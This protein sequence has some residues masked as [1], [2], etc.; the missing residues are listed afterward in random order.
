MNAKRIEETGRHHRA[1]DLNRLVSAGEIE[2]G[3]AH[4]HRAVVFEGLVLRAVIYEIRGRHRG[5][6]T[7]R[8]LSPR[9]HE[10]RGILKWQWLNQ[11]G[12]HHG[13]ECGVGADP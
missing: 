1:F 10:A 6:I 2:E 5:L 7:E 3:I 8:T 11:Y 4:C 12:V 9:P 13:K